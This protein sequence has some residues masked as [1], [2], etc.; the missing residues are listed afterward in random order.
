MKSSSHRQN[1]WVSSLLRFCIF[2][3]LAC[4]LLP[5]ISLDEN[6]FADSLDEAASRNS[7]ALRRSYDTLLADLRE[8][9]PK[10]LLI[11]NFFMPNPPKELA[12]L[13]FTRYSPFNSGADMYCYLV[14]A[15]Y[16]LDQ[17]LY[18]GKLLEML[19][20]ERVLLAAQKSIPGEYSIRQQKLG[21]PS[22][23]GAG[24]YAK[25]GLISVTEIVGDSPWYE[26]MVEMML[27]L[28]EVSETP[29]DFGTLPSKDTELNGDVLQVLPR[30][31][32][33]SG[34]QRFLEFNRRLADAY[35]R[36]VLPSNFFLPMMRWNFEKHRGVGGVRLRD[37]GNE[38]IVGLVLAAVMENL[39]QSDRAAFYL[40][41]SRKMIDRVLESANPDGLFYNSIDEKTLAPLDKE[42]AD[43]WGYVYG[44]VY[45]LYLLTGDEK[46]KRAIEHVLENIDKYQDF[47][48]EGP[49]YDGYA[50]SIESALYLVNRIPNARASAWMDSE[51]RNIWKQQHEDGQEHQGGKTPE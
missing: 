6:A 51:I 13:N 30:L 47:S 31:Y 49:H 43:N 44:A 28:I 40:E 14:I 26:R 33:R 1:K 39:L 9:D 22:L 36:E 23:F 4:V 41:Q 18:Q 19:K 21:G 8:V 15:G 50:D 32:W 5:V 27:D 24:E 11:P 29:S 17:G 25:D 12:R 34:N 7:E 20:S 35:F 2:A 48:W 45:N 16:F 46:Y 42:L 10:S 38:T 37:H 3:S